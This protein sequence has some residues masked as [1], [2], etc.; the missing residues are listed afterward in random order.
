MVCTVHYPFT[1][2][3]A[4]SKRCSPTQ[5]IRVVKRNTRLPSPHHHDH[6][7]HCP[8][9][10]FAASAVPSPRGKHRSGRAFVQCNI[11]II[12]GNNVQAN[13][14][15][16]LLAFLVKRRYRLAFTR[17]RDNKNRPS[18]FR[19]RFQK[20]TANPILKALQHFSRSTIITGVSLRMK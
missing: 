20:P 14:Q 16:K 15:R 5:V 9:G 13:S 10:N 6:M 2:F 17:F 18:P 11:D 19:T 12:E 1:A 4:T 3:G 7:S 8:P